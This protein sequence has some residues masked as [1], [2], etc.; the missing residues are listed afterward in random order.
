LSHN[1]ATFWHYQCI[2]SSVPW[3]LPAFKQGDRR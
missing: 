3:G 2:E 1:P